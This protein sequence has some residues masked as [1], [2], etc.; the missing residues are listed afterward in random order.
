MEMWWKVWIL[1]RFSGHLNTPLLLCSPTTTFSVVF[2]LLYEGYFRDFSWVRDVKRWECQNTIFFSSTSQHWYQLFKKEK[3]HWYPFWAPKWFSLGTAGRVYRKQLLLCH[4]G[5]FPGF[6]SSFP[7]SPSYMETR[8]CTLVTWT[9]P[10][11]LY[12]LVPRLWFCFPQMHG[13]T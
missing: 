11:G 10:E 9:G 6:K 4:C 5:S 12:G 13:F 1:G 2:P 3:K 8:A 7:T